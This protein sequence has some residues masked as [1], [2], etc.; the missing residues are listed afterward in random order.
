MLGLKANVNF[1]KTEIIQTMFFGHSGIKQE[2]KRIN[3]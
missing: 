1:Q 3:K 2:I